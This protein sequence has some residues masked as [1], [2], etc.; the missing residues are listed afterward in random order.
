MTLTKSMSISFDHFS[1]TFKGKTKVSEIELDFMRIE[2]SLARH[3]DFII[4]NEARLPQFNSSEEAEAK[5]RKLFAKLRDLKSENVKAC[6]RKPAIEQRMEAMNAREQ[7][8]AEAN[9]ANEELAV[10]NDAIRQQ[11]DEEYEQVL[12]NIERA[13]F[14]LEQIRRTAEDIQVAT[15]EAQKSVDNAANEFM[16][17]ATRLAHLKM[18]EKRLLVL[19]KQSRKE[20]RSC[21]QDKIGYEGDE[22]SVIDIER[23]LKAQEAKLLKYQQTL[24]E[25]SALVRQKRQRIATIMA[26][27]GTIGQELDVSMVQDPGATQMFS[28]GSDDEIP[29]RLSNASPL[30]IS[31]SPCLSDVSRAAEAALQMPLADTKSL[32]AR[33]EAKTSGWR[34]SKFV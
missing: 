33:I 27:T 1:T 24:K 23:D 13:K 17:K 11:E 12:D 4:E 6:A 8:L 19:E 10:K 28:D 30:S 7:E 3:S 25:K 14:R 29:M 34:N 2:D 22:D 16:E 15:D 9:E 20:I 26:N 21:E 32:R 18:Q 5:L 31:T